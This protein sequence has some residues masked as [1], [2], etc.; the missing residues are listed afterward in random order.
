MSLVFPVCFFFIAG[1]GLCG[2]LSPHIAVIYMVHSSFS[3]D[4]ICKPNNPDMLRKHLASLDMGA[5]VHCFVFFNVMSIS[6]FVR[7]INVA[8]FGDQVALI[9]HQQTWCDFTFQFISNP[10]EIIEV[11]L[12]V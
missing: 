4:Y 8:L 10:I 11:T 5:D 3:F 2:A 12:L 6:L 7:Y 9:S 1:C